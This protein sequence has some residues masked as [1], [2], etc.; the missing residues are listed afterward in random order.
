[1]LQSL[2]EPETVALWIANRWWS[3][4]LGGCGMGSLLRTWNPN[5]WVT[6]PCTT[7]SL[8]DIDWNVLA[9][10]EI[11]LKVWKRKFSSMWAKVEKFVD[12]MIFQNP[13]CMWYTRGELKVAPRLNLHLKA[14]L[15]GMRP[16]CG[17]FQLHR[18]F[19]TLDEIQ[20]YAHPVSNC[21]LEKL[22]FQV[23]ESKFRFRS[24]NRP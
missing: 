14:C 22:P 8:V 19:R 11:A 5:Q 17:Q 7:C 15:D 21:Y 1:M 2:P 16:Y 18:Q 3:L 9:S 4:H 13:R 10:I 12:R 20:E 24:Y 6:D 23:S